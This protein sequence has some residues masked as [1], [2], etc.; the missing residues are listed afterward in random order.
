MERSLPRAEREAKVERDYLV[1]STRL[2][3]QLE[4]ETGSVAESLSSAMQE[5]KVNHL[6]EK[7]AIE[8]HFDLR[9]HHI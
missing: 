1:Q 6:S 2:R 9:K 4:Q 3:K 8:R 7:S 5:I